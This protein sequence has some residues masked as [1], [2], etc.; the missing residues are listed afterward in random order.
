MKKI[1]DATPQGNEAADIEPA[2]YFNLAIEQINEAEVWMRDT[3]EVAQPLLLHIEVFVML[4]KKYKD[5]AK[6]RAKKLDIPQIKKTFNEWF[7]RVKIPAQFKAGIKASGDQLI[8]ELE[9]I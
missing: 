6:G 1:F 8:A 2:R 7:E 4:A 9:A 3:K 5:L